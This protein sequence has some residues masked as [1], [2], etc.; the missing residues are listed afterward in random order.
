MLAL[1]QSEFADLLSIDEGLKCETSTLQS[2]YGGQIT[3]S[4]LLIK[5]AN[6]R[7]FFVLIQ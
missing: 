2:L 7:V 5:P 6:M 4:A 3:S 1:C